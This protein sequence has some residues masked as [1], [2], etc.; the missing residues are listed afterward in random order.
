M[1]S[2][3]FVDTSYDMETPS[4]RKDGRNKLKKLVSG[5]D[6]LME[7]L[8]KRLKPENSLNNM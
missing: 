7:S 8:I 5:E 2:I 1:S 6:V 4:K 3:N